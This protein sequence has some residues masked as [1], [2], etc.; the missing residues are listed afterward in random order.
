MFPLCH[1]DAKG[2]LL[3][4][5][6]SL[7]VWSRQVV[8]LA[9]SKWTNTI[10]QITIEPFTSREELIEAEMIAIKAEFPRFNHVHNG[11]S[12]GREAAALK[13]GKI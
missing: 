11:R 13:G 6:M 7:N 8:H 1:Y 10:C 12:L 9:K 3:Y 5:G 2:D 4:V